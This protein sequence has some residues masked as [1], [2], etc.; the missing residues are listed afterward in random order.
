[1][2]GTLPIPTLADRWRELS[3]AL[4]L[5]VEPAE[6]ATMLADLRAIEQQAAN[7]IAA[8]EP[9]DVMTCP[10]CGRERCVRWL[11]RWWCVGCDAEKLFA[12]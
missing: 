9:A 10:Q 5:A 7:A 8:G 2:T 12:D 1:M 11:G 6:R 3:A 4:D